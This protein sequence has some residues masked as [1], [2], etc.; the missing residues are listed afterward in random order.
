MLARAAMNVDRWLPEEGAFSLGWQILSD[1]KIENMREAIDPDGRQLHPDHHFLA[2]SICGD[3]LTNW[4][5]AYWEGVHRL[6]G[7]PN[8]TPSC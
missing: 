2:R 8:A 6:N 5:W 4:L 1:I 3:A 7:S